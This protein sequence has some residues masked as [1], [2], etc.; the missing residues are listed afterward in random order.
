MA[1]PT[2]AAK[3]FVFIMYLCNQNSGARQARL[4]FFARLDKRGNKCKF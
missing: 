3:I 4:Q 2:T 1:I